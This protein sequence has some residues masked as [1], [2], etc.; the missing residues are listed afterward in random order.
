MSSPTFKSGAS[1][2]MT[3]ILWLFSP[4][5]A[6]GF[7]EFLLTV[8][9]MAGAYVSFLISFFTGSLLEIPTIDGEAVCGEEIHATSL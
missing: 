8:A 3:L 2:P 1:M 4:F 9:Y 6:D 7:T 5:S